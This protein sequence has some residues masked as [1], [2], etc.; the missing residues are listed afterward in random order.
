MAFTARQRVL[1]LVLTLIGGAAWWLQ[2]VQGPKEAP[3]PD[4]G[5]LPD[6]TVEQF[7]ATTMDLTGRPARNLTA[8]EMRH[9][10]D[11]DSNELDGPVLVLHRPDG[12]PWDIRAERGWVSGDGEQVL[13]HGQVV[14]DRPGSGEAR[15]I[16][17]Q[18]SELRVRPRQEYAETAMPVEITSEG[19]WLRATGMQVWFAE[20]VM[21]AR[22]LGRARGRFA[23]Q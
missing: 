19:D 11:D 8:R 21:R 20:T 3:P 15:P 22:F 6:Y 9:Y 18:T 4:R 16:R 23:V 2:L 5:R 7:T 14:A 1:A 10:P 12:P 17:L 13:L